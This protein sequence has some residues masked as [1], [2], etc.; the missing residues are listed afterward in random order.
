MEL[1]GN[2][3]IP[4]DYFKG[5]LATFS[6]F[7]CV[8]N[9]NSYTTARLLFSARSRWYSDAKPTVRS[10]YALRISHEEQQSAYLK[11]LESGQKVSKTSAIDELSGFAL[12]SK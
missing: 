3:S 4:V 2:R 8:L 5:F 12:A 10:S 6:F 1:N 11:R 7:F 9:V